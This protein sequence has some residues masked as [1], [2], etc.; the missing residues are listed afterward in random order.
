MVERN[1]G[2]IS[3]E[4]KVGEG[5]LFTLRFPVFDTEESQ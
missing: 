4:S 1:G 2:Q 3:L 5:S